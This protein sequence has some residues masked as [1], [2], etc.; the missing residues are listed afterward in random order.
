[1]SL[2]T[3]I[4]IGSVLAAG[5]IW[6]SG[7]LGGRARAAAERADLQARLEAERSRRARA[8]D[9]SARLEAELERREAEGRAASGPEP[10]SSPHSTGAPGGSL[11]AVVRG[12]A[13]RAESRSTV[14]ADDLGFPVVGL[15]EHQESLA[16]LC[17]LILEVRARARALLPLGR[18]DRVTLETDEGLTV[19]AYAREHEDIALTLATLTSGP[20]LATGELRAAL[21]DVYDALALGDRAEKEMTS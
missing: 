21:H 3:G 9:V 7:F 15:G 16:A 17:G 11:D 20:G 4:W 12:L 19:S 5:L 18:V 2:L 13:A 1:M 14:I 6:A 10:R 8:E